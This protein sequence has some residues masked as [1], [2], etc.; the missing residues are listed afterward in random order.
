MFQNY[1]SLNSPES[2]VRSSRLAII[3]E[4]A[5]RLLF[6][7]PRVFDRLG[8]NKILQE[9]VENCS[10]AFQT[11]PNLVAA[12]QEIEA[13]VASATSKPIEIL[14][15]ED[16][17]H[18]SYGTKRVNNK[19]RKMYGPMTTIF[20]HVENF[21][22][23]TRPSNSFQSTDSAVLKHDQS[24]WGFPKGSPDFSMVKLPS[25]LPGT[26][27]QRTPVLW[28]QTRAFCEVKP[29]TEQGP[30]SSDPKF[31][32][33]IVCQAADHARLL[34]SGQPFQ[35]FTFGLLIFGSRFCVAVFDR[36]GV[37]FSPVH[38]VWEDISVLIRVIRSLTCHLSDVEFGQDPTVATLSNR[39][40]LIWIKQAKELGHLALADF[41]TFVIAMGGSSNRSWKTIGIP[42]W[43]SV[44]LLGR[45]TSIWLVRED[46][47]GPILVLKNTWRRDSR[48]SESLIYRSVIGQHPALAKFR[49]G[50]DV[51]F[52]GEER[53]ITV[54]NMRGP[55]DDP[56]DGGDVGLHRLLL[57]NRGRPIWECDSEKELLQGIR[58]ALTAHE[59]LTDQG[60]LHRDIS[61][62]NIMLPVQ[63]PPE[64]GAEGFLMDL[65]FAHVER[66][67]IKNVSPKCMPGGGMTSPAVSTK[68]YFGPDVL[69]GAA[70]TGTA[71]FMA[72]EL[73]EAIMNR[74]SIKHE[75]RHDIESFIYVL[76]YAVIK[77]AV[78][79][80]RTLDET[81][82]DRLH[83][84][85]YSNFGRMT[86]DDISTS[87]RGRTPLLFGGRFPDLVSEPLAKLMSNLDVW[88][89]RTNPM[90]AN[91]EPFT[92]T[93]FLS[94]LDA[95]IAQLT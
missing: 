9:L 6:D 84:F 64:P 42:I 65:E 10:V 25:L 8:V 35:L 14:E 52:P 18:D 13:I 7:D 24:T 21:T 43:T 60:I 67:A 4:L 69:R 5:G 59:F 48:N 30:I 46:D 92:Y 76:A 31:V 74:V 86:L 53:Y 80:S 89:L 39:E 23:N 68:I 50:Q 56:G 54:H 79:R 57:E 38:D 17:V 49:E 44:S 85:F 82:P 16:D 88:L 2:G 62:G 93:Y 83:T 41:P 94:E 12:K 71:Q 34:L 1:M 29:T 78:L 75:T 26:T 70:M 77:R 28:R 90:L 81:T 91:P 47:T 61:T 11:D 36:D 15:A 58:A 87:R 20:Q 27:S 73:L 32:K 37:Q 40:H 51:K 45:G 95:A 63:T 22:P 55:S 19:E 3:D 66:N 33:A 72:V